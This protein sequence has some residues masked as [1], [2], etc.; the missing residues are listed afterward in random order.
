MIKKLLF[1]AFIF[2]LILPR[3][4]W[5]QNDDNLPELE[6]SAPALGV[7]SEKSDDL[8]YQD[9]L[10]LNEQ[11]LRP[12]V[13][14]YN[15]AIVDAQRGR[16]ALA[17]GRLRQ[18]LF[19]NPTFKE[20][21]RALEWAMDEM[22]LKPATT[23][24]ETVRSWL[25]MYQ[26]A[27]VYPAGV[28]LTLFVGGWLLLSWV[29]RYRLNRAQDL[30]RPPLPWPMV[31]LL[32]LTLILGTLWALRSWDRNG[33]ERATFLGQGGFRV[34]PSPDAPEVAPLKAGEEILL[35]RSHQGWFLGHIPGGAT[36]WI[37]ED[38]LYITT[39]V[40]TPE[41]LAKH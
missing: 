23:R 9:V 22:A 21:R 17:I 24:F 19:I 20:A 36:G 7:P 32:S 5:G 31:T 38:S 25:W 15:L 41:D 4:T 34:S 29:E 14:L 2:T 12:E 13:Q 33:I 28:L 10:S 3:M 1:A 35:E 6:E 37:H 27:W 40:P 30:D 16:M 18:S 39:S 26:P 8:G 11:G